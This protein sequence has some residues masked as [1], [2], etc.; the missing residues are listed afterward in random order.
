MSRSRILTFVCFVFFVVPF[1]A[2]AADV[3]FVR[4]WPAWRT[5]ESFDRI[6]EYFDG[7][8]NTGRHT[9]LRSQPDTRAGYYFLV[10]TKTTLNAAD[11]KFVLQIIKPAGKLSS[12]SVS[13]VS[14]GPIAKP[15][16]SRGDS[17][18]STV[19]AKSSRV[20]KVSSGPN[21]HRDDGPLD[22]LATA[23]AAPRAVRGGPRGDG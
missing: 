13:P 21:P 7:Q 15:I 22:S 12:T 19:R 17:P 6:S 20:A 18:S 16:P 10:R 5:A 9:V 1:L 2:H 14:I 11:A 4:I 3:E 8:E 23:R